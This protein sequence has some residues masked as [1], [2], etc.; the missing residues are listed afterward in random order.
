MTKSKHE[1][2]EVKAEAY[3]DG[4]FDGFNSART[5]LLSY[6]K[7]PCD[8]SDEEIIALSEDAQE[9]YRRVNLKCAGLEEDS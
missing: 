7:H 2:I 9:A 8:H 5:L 4:W 6:G 3:G 1:E